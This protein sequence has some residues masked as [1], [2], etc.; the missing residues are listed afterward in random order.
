MV[1]PTIYNF[2]DKI[3]IA[4]IAVAI[5]SVLVKVVFF[6]GQSST[7]LLLVK[8][9]FAAIC[10]LCGLYLYVSDKQILF[11]VP[12]ALFGISSFVRLIG[13]DSS[14]ML[15]ILL[16][17]PFLTSAIALAALSWKHSK[18]YNNF[19]LMEFLLVVFLLI[20]AS[21]YVI[22]LGISQYYSFGICF[23]ASTL[24]YN[25]NLWGRYKTSEKNLLILL[26]VYCFTEVIEVSASYLS[27]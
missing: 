7:E 11:L 22:D 21:R 25:N 8:I 12:I 4:L 24:M 23:L 26:L 17:L 19:E 14:L 18:A 16:A 20:T 3:E 1:K 27:F 6:S 5:V 2:K 10:A 13:L 9:S 15:T